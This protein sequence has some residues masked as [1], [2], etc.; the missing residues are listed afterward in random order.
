MK[1]DSCKYF[2]KCGACQLR[3]LPYEEQLS[4]KMS[5]VIKLLGRFCHV[6]EIVGMENTAAY[7]NKAQAV[8]YNQSGRVFSGI[9]QSASGKVIRCD[10]CPVISKKAGLIISEI[11]SIMNELKLKAYDPITKKGFLRHVLVRHGFLSGEIMVV[12]VSATPYFPKEKTFVSLL[13]ERHPQITSIVQNVNNTETPL[14]LTDTERTVYGSGSITDYLCGATFK[15]SPRSFYQINPVQTEKLYKT[16][17][18]LAALG[19][20]EKVLDAYSGI[21]TIGIIASKYAKTVHCVESNRA[22][23]T[24]AVENAKINKIYNVKFFA[25]DSAKF[26]AGAA[27]KGSTYDVVFVDPP[28]AGCDKNFLS[29]LMTLSPDKIIYISCNP[30]TMARDIAYLGG[31]SY[32]VKKI[33]PFD[34]FPHTNHTE[35]VA[36]LTR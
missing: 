19:G 22:A 6:D 28:R 29:K 14:W 27:A 7:R 36:L 1:N 24:D 10:T 11:T 21:G 17:L 4:F 12:L 34:M 25:C 5:R 18:S 23:V 26:V 33:I 16:A 30:E 8:F 9:Y 35:C 2:K 3:N 32:R 20:R 13:T 15:I 31:G